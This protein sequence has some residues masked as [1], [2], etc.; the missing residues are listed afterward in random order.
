[1]LGTEEISWCHLGY[2]RTRFYIVAA[3]VF[4]GLW[5]LDRNEAFCDLISLAVLY[6][7]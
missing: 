2:F 3:I 7:F 5:V 4:Y 6:V 1:M